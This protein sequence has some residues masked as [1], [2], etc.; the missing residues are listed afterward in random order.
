MEKVVRL[1]ITMGETVRPM[2]QQE[3][4]AEHEK[5]E[6]AVDMAM[7]KAIQFEEQKGEAKRVVMV[8]E[9]VEDNVEEVNKAHGIEAFAAGKYVQAGDL[10]V[11]LLAYA[12]AFQMNTIIGRECWTGEHRYFGKPLT[13]MKRRRALLHFYD[14]P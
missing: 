9:E 2:T 11:S 7:E 14:H 13:Q 10:C 5:R 4:D 12:Y 6:K 3:L 1:G 8:D